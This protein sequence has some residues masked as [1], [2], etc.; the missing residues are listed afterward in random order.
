MGLILEYP[1]N[2]DGAQQLSSPPTGLQQGKETVKPHEEAEVE[3]RGTVL[4]SY[5]GAIQSCI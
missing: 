2:R 4:R 1:K 3:R 5:G